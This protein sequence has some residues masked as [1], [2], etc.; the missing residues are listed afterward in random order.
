MPL[1]GLWWA[2]DMEDFVNG[3]RNKWQWTIM[4]MQP[5]FIS[6]SLINDSIDDTK[7]HKPFLPYEKLRFDKFK[8]GSSCQIMHIGPFSEEQQN[9]DK[10]HTYIK[11]NKGVFDGKIQKYHEIYL[12]DFRKIAP[13]K[14]KTILRQSFRK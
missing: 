13:N 11:E 2:D 8:E 5:P 4:I 10:I 3:N 12:T 6:E 1:E 7:K 14:M 9:I